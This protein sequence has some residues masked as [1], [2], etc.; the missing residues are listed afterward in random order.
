L[1]PLPL[2]LYDLSGEF[3]ANE[4]EEIK[5]VTP[6]D[7]RQYAFLEADA[8]IVDTLLKDIYHAP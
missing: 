6:L 7:L 4:H 2:L 5:W 8:P 1:E 3:Q